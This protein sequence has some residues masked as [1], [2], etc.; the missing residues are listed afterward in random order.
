MQVPSLSTTEAPGVATIAA[1]AASSMARMQKVQ[2][3]C[4]ALVNAT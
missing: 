3:H 1:I 4:P 2:L